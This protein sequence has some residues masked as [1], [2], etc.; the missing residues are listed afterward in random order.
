[1]EKLELINSGLDV[2]EILIQ[3]LSK[4]AMGAD[5]LKKY[6]RD[7][8]SYKEN[9]KKQQE[10]LNQLLAGSNAISEETKGV[11]EKLSSNNER[12]GSIYDEISALRE[13]VQKMEEDQKVYQS[14]FNELTVQIA[15]ITNL[16]EAI[17]KI[18]SQTRLLS[19]NASIE[20][21][22][23]GTAGKG[24]RIIANEVKKLSD[25]TDKASETIMG[26]VTSLVDSL[27][28]LE[29]RTKSN[30]AALSELTKETDSTLQKF[31]NVRQLNSENNSAVGVVAEHVEENLNVINTILSGIEKED[32]K[33]Q[34]T[35]VLFAKSASENEMLF[36]DL[37]SFAYE[38]KSIFEELK[39]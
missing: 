20:A 30:S 14:K 11:S 26:K 6:L 21:A 8:E 25:D 12:L 23:A 32:S 39:K 28:K 31:D 9:S 33:K 19:F 15:E 1:M 34:N 29:D 5:F 37:Y 22:R 13:S 16:I 4:D 24:F 35:S 18:S 3:Y 38:I 17:K 27:D 10:V 36:N 7:S 2:S